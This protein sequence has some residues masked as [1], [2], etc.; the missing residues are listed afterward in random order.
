VHTVGGIG[1]GTS[2][3]DVAGMLQAAIDHGAMGGSLYDY[4]TTGDDLWQPMQGF[5]VAPS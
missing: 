3:D 5:R 4:R 2:P 1:D